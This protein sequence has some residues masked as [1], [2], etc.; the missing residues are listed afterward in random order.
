MVSLYKTIL[1]Y[2]AVVCLTAGV[3]A[4]AHD[5]DGYYRVA[6]D[7]CGVAGEQNH[8]IAGSPYTYPLK[9]VPL[10]VIAENDPARTVA[11][12]A[13]QVV[14]SYEGLPKEAA[15]RL[16]LTLLS[17]VPRCQTI[18][19]NDIQVESKFELEAG[20][21]YK[22]EYDLPKR[23]YAKGHFEVRIERESGPNAVVSEA[24]LYSTARSLTPV[25][26]MSVMGNLN[27]Q[28]RG[29]IM[30]LNNNTPAA[31]VSVTVS[32]GAADLHLSTETDQAGEFCFTVPGC[33]QR[34]AQ[35]GLQVQA[36]LDSLSLRQNIDVIELFTPQ[37][38]PRPTQTGKVQQPILSLVGT[39]KFSPVPPQDFP[40]HVDMVYNFSDINVPGEWVMQGFEVPRGQAAG[41]YR[42]F[43]APADYQGNRIILHC[44]AVYADAEVWINGD[45]VGAHAGGMTAFQLDVT[46][47][48]KPGRKNSIA[49]KV[50]NETQTDVLASGS[51]YAVHPLGGITRKLYLQAVPRTAITT[52]DIST[53]FDAEYCDANIHI[54][55]VVENADERIFDSGHVRFSL[56]DGSGQRIAL[57][58]SKVELAP[59]ASGERRC[60]SVTLHVPRPQKWDS[61]HPHLYSL[62]GK[63]YA[64]NS[65]IEVVR[66]R[67]GFRQIEVRGDRVFVNNHP[68]KLR[69]VNR[70]EVHPLRGRSLTP[71][72]WRRDA[73]LFRAANVNY[74]RTSHYPPAEEFLDA[75]DE[76]GLFVEC[77]AP[78]CWVQH[79]ANANWGKSG[80]NYL[81]PNFYVPLL[82]AN[83]EN[84]AFNRRHP[85]IIIWSLANE[86]RWSPLWANVLEAVEQ[87]DSTR[88]TAFHDQCY[89]GYNNAESTARIANIHYPGPGGPERAANQERPLLFGEYCHLNAYN[90]HELVTDPGLRDAWGRGFKAMWDKMY[91]TRGC[92]GG[93]LW[94]GIDDTFYLPSGHTVGYG[95]WGPIDGWRRPKP[96]YFHVKK[97]YSPVRISVS[98]LDPPNAED[99]LVIPV[100]NRHD[101]TNLQELKIL[102]RIGD[103]EGHVCADIPPHHTG[104]LRIKPSLTQLEGKMI[105]LKFIH[106]NR[107]VIDE[108]SLP[109]GKNTGQEDTE[110]A[111]NLADQ[112]LTLR[113]Q[114]DTIVIQG[115]TLA[116][117]IDRRSGQI[118]RAEFNG[119]PILLGGPEL[120]VLPLNA[121]GG[122]QMTKEVQEFAPF[123]DVCSGRTVDRVIAKQED[124]RIVIEVSDKYAQAYGGY[125]LIVDSQGRLNIEYAYEML[126]DISP[127][128]WGMVVT[129]SKEFDT[130]SWQREGLWTVYPKDHIGRLCGTSRAFVGNER[131]GPSGPRIRPDYAWM[132]DS[133]PLGTNDFRS[134]KETIYHAT[135]TNSMDCGVLVFSDGS[136]HIR[137]WIDNQR[138]M[139]L[140]AEYS[141]AGAERFFRS[142]AATE[143]RPL[144]VGDIIKG[145]I[146]LG[147]Q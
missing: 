125:R 38:I 115:K 12:H 94:S 136:Q 122:T 111:S 31:N 90:R 117:E 56:Y 45:R 58:D 32:V 53:V 139:L 41:Y 113:S 71:Q 89:G 124:G 121:K 147:L 62:E 81:D 108:Y 11:F 6:F 92:L 39:W 4:S 25:L 67:F 110:I 85:S 112:A 99:A 68:I 29:K 9:D 59:I 116:Y 126:Q 55:L 120:L 141:N 118:M 69:G 75:C 103:K 140:V 46:D 142:H 43:N 91:R 104:Q 8:V 65:I 77:E 18:Y 133:S 60:L 127:R 24:V 129:V 22:L 134:T 88:P 61:E 47:Q 73:E 28:I 131:C 16:V 87:Y 146:H 19:F 74:I 1:G 123:T 144:K 78:L 35:N 13:K 119:V 95:T 40:G 83:L 34:A 20:Q 37:L 21:V 79:G 72:Q 3:H 101:F 137:T 76:L 66:R 49:M 2:V 80:W 143:D 114:G 135:L 44:D 48:V 105:Y 15:Y 96:E 17:D 128:Q 130:L 109:I 138:I 23:V 33:W 106:S 86:S 10:Q 7:N 27:R 97:T 132:L 70:H 63:L 100:E 26:K 93:A 36:I 145:S 54:A 5:V 64:D 84:I 30:D 42:E 107:G 14:L 52:L 51:Q 57:S 50:V 98:Y 102:W 82:R